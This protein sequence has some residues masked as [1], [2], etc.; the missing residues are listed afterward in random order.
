MGSI[1]KLNFGNSNVQQRILTIIL[2]LNAI[3]CLSS[4]LKENNK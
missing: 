1:I 4:K 3:G 2:I